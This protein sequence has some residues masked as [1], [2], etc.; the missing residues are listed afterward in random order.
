VSRKS[1]RP[2]I[3]TIVIICEPGNLSVGQQTD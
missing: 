1:E 2:H 3:I